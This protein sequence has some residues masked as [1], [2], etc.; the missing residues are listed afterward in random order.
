MSRL[1]KMM[2]RRL[3]WVFPVAFGVVTLTFFMA[4]S[5]RSYSRKR[6]Y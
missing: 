4:I 6:E 3:L 1:G 2:L 5:I